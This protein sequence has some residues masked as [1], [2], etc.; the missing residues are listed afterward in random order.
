VELKTYLPMVFY[1]HGQT[2]VANDMVIELCSPANKRRDYPENAYTIIEDIT[3][4]LMGIQVNAA[5]GSFSTL[6]R[7]EKASEWAELQQVPLLSNLVSVKHVGQQKTTVI[8]E[9]GPD[10]E[11]MA[12]IPG[13]HSFLLV[14]GVKKKCKQ[15]NITGQIY[16]YVT[17]DLPIGKTMTVSFE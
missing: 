6:P 7:L 8:N 13:S 4:G 5:E 9:K 11:W 2:K 1:D 10:L 12:Q 16:S 15:S 17:V 3:R 14:N